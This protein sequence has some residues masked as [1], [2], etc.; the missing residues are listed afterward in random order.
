M[1]LKQKLNEPLNNYER[2][3]KMLNDELNV[4]AANSSAKKG[5]EI[6]EK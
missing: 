6:F 4:L 3:K 1:I 5:R 2:N